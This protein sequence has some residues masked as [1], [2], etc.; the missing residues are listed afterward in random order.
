[1]NAASLAAQSAV[2][3]HRDVLNAVD[4]AAER[5]D[6]SL[7]LLLVDI[8]DVSLLQ[9]RLGFDAGADLFQHLADA[10]GNVA[11]GRGEAVRLGDGRYALVVCG[12]KNRGHAV[13]AAEKILRLADEVMSAQGVTIK[14]QVHV[15]IALFPKQTQDSV[16][17]LRYA[18]LAAA[19]ARSLALRIQV[20]D[21]PCADRVL[22]N[23]QLSD[24]YAK[25][26]QG[27]ELSVFYQPKIRI[28]DGRPAPDETTRLRP[29]H[30]H[31]RF[32]HGLLLA[33]L[34]QENA[35]R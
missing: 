23:W 10:F 11:S 16:V 19:A 14:P 4:R 26:L 17:L 32:R 29:A 18:Q 2:Q 3:T 9:A 35:V 6:A 7:A 25:A 24:A 12:I 33:E 28:A 13:L 34:S 22:C 1:M 20:Y 5:R 15:G 31:R 27:G 8:A 21:Q 30:F